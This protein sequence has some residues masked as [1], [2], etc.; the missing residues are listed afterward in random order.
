[1][2]R[3]GGAGGRATRLEAERSSALGLQLGVL[4]AHEGD[5]EARLM[6]GLMALQWN[7][8][9]GAIVSLTVL[10]KFENFK[11]YAIDSTKFSTKCSR[12][13]IV[14]AVRNVQ[15]AQESQQQVLLFVVHVVIF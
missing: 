14:Y 15:V 3:A 6:P 7:L 1:M 13:R 11:I 5:L 4:N 10:Q 2:R 12:R 8:S 9:V